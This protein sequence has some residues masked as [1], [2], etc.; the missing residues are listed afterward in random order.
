MRDVKINRAAQ[1]CWRRVSVPPSETKVQG[2]MHIL[3]TNDDGIHA[4][5]LWALHEAFAAHGQV[6]V[7]AP[8]RERSAVGH[9]ITLHTPLRSGEVVLEGGRKGVAVNG[10]PAD[11]VKLALHALLEA[12][13]DLVVSGINPGANVGINLNYSG[14][15]AAAKEAALF[16]VPALAASIAGAPSDRMHAVGRFVY[17]V[18]CELLQKP[19]SVGTFLNLNFPDR[20]VAAA[21]GVKVCRQAINGDREFFVK[22]RDPR[23]RAYYWAGLDPSGTAADDGADTT[24][25]AKGYIC[26]TPVT[27]DMTDH[28]ALATLKSW[29]LENGFRERAAGGD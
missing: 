10:K 1:R 25:L 26:I 24:A 21:A 13:P 6:T 12:P 9:G 3:L 8:D 20:S 19:L 2:S 22:R 5:G 27:C 4:P 14:T 18:A 28:N 23:Q 15:V 29:G 17:R 11:C 16:G 7:V